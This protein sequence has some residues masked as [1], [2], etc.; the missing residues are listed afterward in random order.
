MKCNI[1]PNGCDIKEGLTGLCRAR[2]CSGGEIVSLNYGEITSLALDPIEKKPLARFY[3]G[4]RILSLGSWGCNLDCP[5][6]QNDSISRGPAEHI[7]VS[8]EDIVGKAIELKDRGNIGIA[9]TYNEPGI[10]PEFIAD[11]S[12]LAHAEGLKNVMVTNGMITREAHESFINYID[13]YNIDLKTSSA[14][15]YRSIRGNLQAV[16]ET[17]KR[18]S[19]KAHVEV[20]TLV[21]PGFNDTEDEI[22]AIAGFIAGINRDIP[23]HVSRFHPAG[24]MM[25]TPPT[26]VRLVYHFAELAREY[27][28]YVY[29]GNC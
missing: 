8:P 29:T 18:A 14:E 1:C 2:T 17:I 19:E 12:T 6:C 23:L 9:Y 15:K 3:P 22:C 4:T 25:D 11:T 27:L 28:T 5:W 13:A 21:V 7:T 10:C 26:D 16:Q 24:R 20:T